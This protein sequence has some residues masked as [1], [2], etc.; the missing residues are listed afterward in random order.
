MDT[1][2]PNR[3]NRGERLRRMLDARQEPVVGDVASFYLPYIE[4]A[5]ALEPSIRIVCLTR[6]REE[7]VE[8]FCRSLDGGFPFPVNHW[9]REPA[10]GWHHDPILSRTFPQYDTQDRTEGIRHMG[11]IPPAGRGVAAALPRQRAALGHRGLDHRV[12]GARGAVVRRHSRGPAGDPHGQ[13]RS[14]ECARRGNEPPATPRLHGSASLR[15]PGPVFGL[16]S[17]RVREHVGGTGAEGLSGVA[18]GRLRGDR[19][20]PQS[21]GNRC[22]A[23]GFRGNALGSTRTSLSIRTAWTSFAPAAIRSS[24]AFVPRRANVRWPA[25]S[26]PARRRWFSAA[27][28]ID[29]TALRGNGI[30][31]DPAGGLP[32]DAAEAEPGGVQRAI[33][34]SHDSFL[35]TDGPV[36][37]RGALVSG[38]GLCVLSSPRECGYRLY[39]DTSIRLWHIGSYRYGWKDAG[40]E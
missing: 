32:N 2:R 36:H 39:A 4:E 34:T 8:G 10:P 19:P 11:R 16:H 6:P 7:V 9:S 24:P 15:H 14:V 20:G 13:T 18:C 3:G 22:V 27:W 12:G 31:V 28:W 21:D 25:M 26:C 5:V 1:R 17:A 23:G 37:R 29:G 30:S 33:R 35:S 40:L 38:R